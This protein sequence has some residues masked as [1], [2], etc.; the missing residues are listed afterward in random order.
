MPSAPT[1]QN[2]RHEMVEALQGASTAAGRSKSMAMALALMNDAL[3]GRTEK[4]EWFHG[5]Q[6]IE[7][8]ELPAGTPCIMCPQISNIPLLQFTLTCVSR[9]GIHF[10]ALFTPYCGKKIAFSHWET[11]SEAPES[12]A[13]PALKDQVSGPAFRW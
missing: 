9:E 13:D 10:S 6:A 11:R 1:A 3:Q 7:M 4:Q 5:G 12:R 8:T 2:G